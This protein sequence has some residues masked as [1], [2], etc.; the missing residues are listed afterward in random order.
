MPLSMFLGLVGAAVFSSTLF[1][2]DLKG[3]EK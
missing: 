3:P 2:V 1:Y